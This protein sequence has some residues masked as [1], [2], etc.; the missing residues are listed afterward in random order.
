MGLTRF[1]KA[2][3]GLVTA[4]IA[5]FVALGGTAGASEQATVP[6]AKRALVADNA[7][8]LNGLTANQLGGAVVT[9]AL[10]ESPAGPRPASTAAALVVVKTVPFAVGPEA[11]QV[12]TAT[13]D[14]GTKAI[15]GGFTNPTSALV[16]SA[17]SFPTT[18]GAGWTEDLVNVDSSAAS[19]N[20]V[21]TCL[22]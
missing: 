7:K 12:V 15:G 17:G 11:E 18:D 19:G 6:L 5:L 13:C 10:K 14:A 16:L 8:K 2:G 4:L 3:L 21:V 22:K 20:V 1:M 9:V